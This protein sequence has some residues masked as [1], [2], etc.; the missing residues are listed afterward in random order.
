MRVLS[1]ALFLAG[2]SALLCL[3]SVFAGDKAEPGYTPLFNGKDLTGW[4]P[5]GKKDSLAGKTEAFDGR[6]KV[7]NGV[8]VY[9]YKDKIKGDRYIETTKEFGNAHFKFEF[10]AGPACNND[11]LFRGTKFDIVPGKGETKAVKE[12]EWYTFELI[13]AGDKIEHKINGEVVRKAKDAKA[14]M[15]T[16]VLRG[17]RRYRDQ[18]HPRQG[19]MKAGKPRDE[20][21]DS[22]GTLHGACSLFRTSL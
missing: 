20:R 19:I 11:I 9:V 21:S 10:K 15:S 17:V 18:E 12:G 6:F 4:Q 14:K 8:L 3:P 5:R 13:A 1:Y 7:D 2:L 16:F 22:R